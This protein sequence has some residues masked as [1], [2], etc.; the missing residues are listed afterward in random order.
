MFGFIDYFK[1]AIKTA[2]GKILVQNMSYLTILQIASYVFPFI[3]LPYLS[4]VIGVNGF[5]K[6]AFAAAIIVWIQTIVDWGF[7]YIATRDVAR[8][9]D[10]KEIVSHIFSDVLWSRFFLM[11]IAFVVLMILIVSVPTFHENALVILVSFIMIP[12]HILFPDWFFQAIEKMKYIS[13]LN[14]TS[15]FLF[16]VLVFVFIKN[17]DDYYLQPLLTSVGFLV[18][19]AISFYLIVVK[20]G[21]KIHKPSF[22]RLIDTLKNGFDVFLNNLMPNLYN[23]LTVVFL[24]LFGG[25]ESSNGILEAGTRLVNICQSLMNLITR[26]FFPFL[27]R[28]PDNFKIFA[29]LNM[30]A[31]FIVSLGIFLIAPFFIEIFY[32]EEFLESVNVLRLMSLSIFFLALGDTYGTN[33][34]IINGYTRQLRIITTVVSIVGLAI[35]WIL[36]YYFD[37]WGAAITILLCRAMLGLSMMFYANMQIKKRLVNRC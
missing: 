10:N 16:T 13:I 35:S 12:G 37:Y 29:R 22:S 36:V 24:G 23:S 28:K 11:L 2:D 25:G 19:G 9:R 1:K 6:L 14:V 3:T 5:S 18:S 21:V 32:T 17:E 34:L 20:W 27:A 15:K 30:S 33:Y 7:N 31:A 26:T 4:R 8:N